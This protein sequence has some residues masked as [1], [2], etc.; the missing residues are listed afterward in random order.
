MDLLIHKLQLSQTFPN[1]EIMLHVYLSM[2]VSSCM[3][4]RHSTGWDREE[5]ASLNDGTGTPEYVV[6][7]EYRTQSRL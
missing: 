5:C 6:V 7:N 4:N 3:E 1:V 2:M